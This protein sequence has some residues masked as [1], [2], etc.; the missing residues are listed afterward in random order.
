M[1]GNK[2]THLRGSVAERWAFV[3]QQLLA[4]AGRCRVTTLELLCSGAPDMTGLAGVLALC[5]GLVQL[6]VHSNGMLGAGGTGAVVRMVGQRL[7]LTHLGLRRNWMGAE[8]VRQLAV[9]LP[10]FPALAHLDV[11]CNSIGARGMA[12][13]APGLALCAGLAR[14]DVSCNHLGADGATSLGGVLGQCAAL[15]HLNLADNGLTELDR[16]AGGLVECASLTHL[17]LA[18]NELSE[19]GT[20][21]LVGVLACCGLQFLDLKNC[22]RSG[23]VA[24]GLGLCTSL[25]ELSMHYNG[26][27]GPAAVQYAQALQRCPGLVRLDLR[28]NS[29]NMHAAIGLS[30]LLPRYAALAELRLPFNSMRVVGASVL[31]AAA[32]AC[33]TLRR[34]DLQNNY[35]RDEYR[36]WPRSR[37]LR[38]TFSASFLGLLAVL[39]RGTGLHRLDLSFNDFSDEGEQRLL[40]CWGGRAGGLV[41]E[42]A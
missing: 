30:A 11:S 41:L 14:L 39:Q 22:V 24:Q 20:D 38:P 6:H 13:L 1:S 12:A 15:T 5:P 3:L 23:S 2:N 8:G 18:N 35:I 16:L 26:I 4:L 36:M 9:V 7:L 37:D 32:G 10:L 21:M 17:T 29:F 34:L 28:G 40:A 27:S 31:L 33:A 42:E 19:D 25:T